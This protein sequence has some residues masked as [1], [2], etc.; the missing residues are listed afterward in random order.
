MKKENKFIEYSII[1]AGTFIIAAAVY[2]FLM[3]ANL[4]IG[5]ISGLAIILSNLIRINVSYIT[6]ALNI[7]CLILGFV[8]IGNEFGFKTVFTSVLMPLF[9]RLFEYLF[10]NFSSLTG[11]S[12]IDM[13]CYCLVVSI[14][15]AILFVRNAS[16]GGLDIIAKILNKYLKME[17]GTAMSASGIFVSLSSLFFYDTKT[18]IVSL[19][20]TYLN[21]VV[22]DKFIFGLDEKKKVCIISKHFEEIKNYILFELHSGAT[23]YESFGAYGDMPKRLELQVIVDKSEYLK[24]MKFMNK[25][26]PKAFMTVYTLKTITYISPK[27]PNGEIQGK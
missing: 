1:A 5:S 11:E 13:I 17:L 20:G 25:I 14:G 9:L 16:S 18:V 26:D 22:L 27:Y 6:L 19:I 12:F 2:F 4:A 3:P 7:F 15:L 8:L 21:G 10:P 23:V 24:L